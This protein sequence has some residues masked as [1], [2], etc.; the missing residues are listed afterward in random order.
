MTADHIP[1][2]LAW[3]AVAGLIVGRI[4]AG[5]P[6]AGLLLCFWVNMAMNHMFAQL[7]W[8]LTDVW[9]ADHAASSEGFLLTGNAMLGLIAGMLVADYVQ[10]ARQGRPGQP[11]RDRGLPP[12]LMHAY[13]RQAVVFGVAGYL[14]GMTGAYAFIPSLV[15][16]ASSAAGVAVAGICMKFWL[17]SRAGQWP[18]AYQWA[19]GILLYPVVSVIGGGFLGFGM[20]GVIAVACF[21]LPHARV[22]LGAVALAPFAIYAGVSLWVTYAATRSEIRESVWGGRSLEN[23]LDV[24]YNGLVL[25]WKWF[26]LGDA[27]QLSLLERLNQNILVGQ[28]V[29]YMDK[30]SLGYGAGETL[31]NAALSLVPRIIWA[32]KP[33]YAG[34]GT[35]A[36][37]YTGREFSAGTSV[38]IGYL[39]ELYVNFGPWGVAAG[40]FAFG[41]GV[42]WLD[43]AAGT[44]LRA[45]RPL[46]FLYA[47]AFAQP[48]MNAL[49]FSAEAAPSAI[50]AAVCVWAFGRTMA[51]RGIPASLP[52][53][54]PA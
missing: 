16:V 23:R 52:A 38:G 10:R 11:A 2:Y 28:S 15:A 8:D 33:S 41:L 42:T 4:M 54:R 49:S 1:L 5:R 18:L 47:F 14:I 44:G 6:T 21:V 32:D 35:L 20:A 29:W 9:L 45:G 36:S 30:Y 19:A 37:R 24:T 40:Y 39:M 51:S 12:A 34:S 50:G 22:R 31:T 7:C 43:L 27:Y 26:D 3:A 53:G 48:A 17:H 25:N 13:A 46:R